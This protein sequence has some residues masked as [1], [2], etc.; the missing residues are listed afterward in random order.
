MITFTLKN[1]LALVPEAYPLVKQ[2]S[3]EKEFPVDSRDSSLASALRVEYQKNISGIAVDLDD[4]EKVACAVSAY[5]LED[6]VARL[7]SLM[8]RSNLEKSAAVSTENALMEKQASFTSKL[9]GISKSPVELHQEATQIWGMC[10]EAGLTA[11]REVQVYSG[12]SFL[13]KQQTLSALGAR[14]EATGDDRF[15][16]LAAAM[17][18]LP[19]LIPPNSTTTNLLN[20][21]SGMDKSAKLDVLG[22]DIYKEA[23]VA[24][25]TSSVVQVKVGSQQMPL[26]KILRIP[27]HHLSNYLGPDIA[28]EISNSDPTTAKAVVESLPADLQQVLLQVLKSC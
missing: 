9:S 11:D 19:D 12:N 2:A 5:G 18:V 25:P 10:K 17:S 8:L 20:L 6:E 1:I 23:S 4:L 16:K 24:N 13:D 22:F 3:L 15:V 28:K 27:S 7:T 14:F 21:V 26:E